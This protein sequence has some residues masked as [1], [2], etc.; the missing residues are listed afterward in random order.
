MPIGFYGA[1]DLDALL[2]EFG[3]PVELEGQTVQ[4]IVDI[5]DLGDAGE[6]ITKG[7]TV[8]VKTGALTELAEKASIKVDGKKY[9]VTATEQL[10]DGALTRVYG[11]P[12]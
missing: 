7:F 2:A 11:T 8:L 5:A 6:P 3:V 1:S 9:R 10:D 4:G 12:A